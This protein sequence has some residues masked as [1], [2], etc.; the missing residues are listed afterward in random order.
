MKHLFYPKI[1]LLLYAAF[2]LDV[3][4][5]FGQSPTNEGWRNKVGIQLGLHANRT[6]DLSFSPMIY[7]GTSLSALTVAYRHQSKNGL[8][9]ASLGFE[10]V[11]VESADQLTFP[12]FGRSISRQASSALSVN[13]LYGYGH[14]VLAKP[15]S[16]LWIGGLLDAHTQVVEFNYAESVDEGYLVSYAFSIW[17]RGEYRLNQRQVAGV[18]VSFPLVH[19]VSRPPYALVDNEE[20]QSTSSDFAHIHSRGKVQAFSG[21]TKLNLAVDYA[22]ALSSAFDLLLVYHFSFLQVPDPEQLTTVR[23]SFDVGLALKW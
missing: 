5:A 9:V 2:L 7:S 1:H 16:M 3:A 8:H 14:S 21:F 17:G 4:V 18:Q 11:S 6:Q 19:F 20:I 15:K 13:I 22:L 10:D 12:F 23:N